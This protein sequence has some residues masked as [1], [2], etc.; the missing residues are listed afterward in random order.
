LPAD[1][2]TGTIAASAAG[3]RVPGARIEIGTTGMSHPDLVHRLL[4]LALALALVL[5]CSACT[6]IAPDIDWSTRLRGDAV[7]LLGEVHDNAELHRLRLE[8]LR[9]AFSAG[10]RPA[11]AMEQFDRDRQADIDRARLDPSIDAQGL[12]ALA[13]PAGARSGWNWD[14]YRPYVAL[15]LEYGVPLIA[16]NLSNA[17]TAKIVRGGYA[18]VFDAAATESLGLQAPLP[19]DLQ[20]AQ[21]R[22]IDAG[23]CHV[24]PRAAWPQMARAQFARDAVMAQTLRLHAG[25]GGIVLLAGNG[26]VRRDM[27]V[28]RWIDAPLKDRLFAVGYL[29]R[30]LEPRMARAFDAVVRAD[31][32]ERPDPCVEF[33]RRTTP[34]AVATG[35]AS[36]PS[37]S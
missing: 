13:A 4:A 17:D 33:K 3:T 21:E 34:P 8:D 25:P 37:P 7:V 1:R 23:H 19:A 6:T 32:T 30:G 28:P 24:L 36:G 20:A 18:A 14:H 26:H 29:E 27:G 15:A 16:A 9:R 12:I 11:I 10:W 22:E 31:P 5:A 2:R 35:R